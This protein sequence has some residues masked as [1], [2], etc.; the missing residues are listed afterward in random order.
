M[1]AHTPVE[2]F[3]LQLGIKNGSLLEKALDIEREHIEKAF[4]EGQ[5]Q[6]INLEPSWYYNETYKNEKT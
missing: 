3:A 2:W 4:D 1:K 5:K 6:V